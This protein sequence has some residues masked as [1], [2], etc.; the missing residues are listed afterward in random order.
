MAKKHQFTH[1][2]LKIFLFFCVRGVNKTTKK[3]IS[4]V[5][6]KKQPLKHFPQAPKRSFTALFTSHT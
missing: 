6:D 1:P 5:R 4:I 3:A 2:P